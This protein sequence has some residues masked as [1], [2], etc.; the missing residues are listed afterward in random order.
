MSAERNSKYEKLKQSF[1]LSINKNNATIS[2]LN[3]KI[4]NINNEFK[5]LD[6]LIVS[7]INE[8]KN[9][10]D[11]LKNKMNECSLFGEIYNQLENNITTHNN[12]NIVISQKLNDLI[13]STNTIIDNFNM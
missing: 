2:E 11:E 5:K 13:N 4:D 10:D 1:S 12:N 7:K 6:L 3:K 9:L 8:K